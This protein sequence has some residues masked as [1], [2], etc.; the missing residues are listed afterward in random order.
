MLSLPFCFRRIFLK[1]KKFAVT[2]SENISPSVLRI[3]FSPEQERV[4]FRPGQFAYLRFLSESIPPD[5]HPF[6]ISSSPA[7]PEIAVTVKSLG[8]FTEKL[9]LL[10][11]GDSVVFD[12]PMSFTPLPDG[13]EKLFIAGGIGITP[14]LSVLRDWEAGKCPLF[15]PSAVECE[16]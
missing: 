5:E 10:K 12:G 2:G 9:T 15:S 13:R 6:T 16:V 14:F 11:R 8:D 7:E 4:S 1:R 3:R